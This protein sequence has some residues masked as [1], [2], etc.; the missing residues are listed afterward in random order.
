MTITH[1]EKKDR[2]REYYLK[3]RERILEKARARNSNKQD[4]ILSDVIA[5]NTWYIKSGGYNGCLFDTERNVKCQS[6]QRA[7]DATDLSDSPVLKAIWPLQEISEKTA[8]KLKSA[9]N[10]Q[11]GSKLNLYRILLS[12]PLIGRFFLIAGI[13]VLMTSMQVCFYREHDILPNFA[14]PLAI[15]SEL[16]FISLVSLKLKQGWDWVRILVL[17]A[18]F[19][20]FIGASTFHV[21]ANNRASAVSNASLIEDNS[22]IRKRLEGARDS[23]R[24]A[25]SGRSWK[26]MEFFGAEVSKLESN[27]ASIPNEKVLG[28][29]L[30]HVL[31]VQTFLLVL[32]RVLLLAAEVLNVMRI[33]EEFSLAVSSFK[34]IGC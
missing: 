24:I 34:P 26:N 28:V 33:R 21:F 5:Q 8:A 22:E 19:G 9:E 13:N 30:D 23:L 3:N 27:L 32:L 10:K 31:I 17:L 7:A 11:G 6:L 18:F 16:S 4:S 2:N 25:K 1:S 12:T 29:T 14:I 15:V 20:Y